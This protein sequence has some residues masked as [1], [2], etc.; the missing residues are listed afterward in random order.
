MVTRYG[1]SIGVM[2]G[3][4]IANRSLSVLAAGSCCTSHPHFEMTSMFARQPRTDL[5]ESQRIMEA[6]A[7]S[8]NLRREPNVLL[9]KMGCIGAST[10]QNRANESKYNSGRNSKKEERI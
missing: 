6:E 3:E 7:E 10:K 4:R 8:V 9:K 2:D 1:S 5:Q